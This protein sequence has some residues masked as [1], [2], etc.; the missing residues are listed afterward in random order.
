VSF[1]A[2]TSNG[3]LPVVYYEYTTNALAGSPSWRRFNNPAQ[4]PGT[5]IQLTVDS[6]GGTWIPG[7]TYD[8]AVRAVNAIGSTATTSTPVTVPV[9]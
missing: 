5:D 4:G 8:V 1:G 6:A 3:G 9:P 7:N 2:P